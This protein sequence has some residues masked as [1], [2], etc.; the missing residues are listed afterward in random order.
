MRK[1]NRLTAYLD[2]ILN[3]S[4]IPWWEWDIKAARVTFNNLKVINPGYKPEDFKGAVYQEF[5]ALI[6]PEN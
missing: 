4:K 6:H 2:S 3:S 1:Q 5:T